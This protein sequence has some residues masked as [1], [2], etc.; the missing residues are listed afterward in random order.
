MSS[1]GLSQPSFEHRAEKELPEGWA[2][3]PLGI[4]GRWGTGNTP[5]K[6]NER[7]WINGQ[8]PWVSPKDMKV[9]YL[10]DAID[11]VT[12]AAVA[13]GGAAIVPPGTIFFVVRGM[14]LAHTFPVA[15]V[16]KSAAFNQD[17]RSLQPVEGISGPYLLRA[18]QQEAPYILGVVREATHGTLRLESI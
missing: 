1:V 2:Y 16:T 5:S 14:I 8:I 3:A 4:L 15:I 7:F 6:A 18:L 13:S 17:M 11:H 10:S 9:A 12:D